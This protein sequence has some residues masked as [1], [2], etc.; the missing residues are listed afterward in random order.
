MCFLANMIFASNLIWFHVISNALYSYWLPTFI[1]DLIVWKWSF[2]VVLIITLLNIALST[3]YIGLVYIPI[4]LLAPCAVL[5]HGI[6]ILKSPTYTLQY[7]DRKERL[8]VQT[9]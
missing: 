8:L 1:E 6:L 4:L 5:L 7:E 3:I 9:I 2:C